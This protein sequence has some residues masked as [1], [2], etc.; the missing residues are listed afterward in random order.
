L[1]F[2][3]LLPT[4]AKDVVAGLKYLHSKNVAHRD[5][6]PGNILVSNQR[7][8]ST[9]LN[10]GPLNENEFAKAYGECHV[11]CKQADLGLSRFLDLQTKS[12]FMSKTESVSRGIPAYMAPEIHF[13]RLF[14]AS[15]EYLKKADM[16]SLGLG[17]FTLYIVE[18]KPSQSLSGRT[19]NTYQ[20]IFDN[21]Y[22]VVFYNVCKYDQ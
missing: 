18:S 1:S 5:P 21:R 17:M 6:K 2:A 15:Q 8:S 20:C 22:W 12:F 14:Q 3:G 13:H 10:V 9:S 7:Y 11:V 19:G 16:W 4:C